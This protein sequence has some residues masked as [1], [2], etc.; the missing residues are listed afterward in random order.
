MR[1]GERGRREGYGSQ[2]AGAGLQVQAQA[3]GRLERLGPFP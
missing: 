1:L 2:L 3:L